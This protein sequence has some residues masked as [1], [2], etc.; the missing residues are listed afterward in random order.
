MDRIRQSAG[1]RASRSARLTTLKMFGPADQ[2]VPIIS[3]RVI[4]G[5]LFRFLD[6]RDR[7][8]FKMAL[9][10]V[11][12]LVCTRI[13]S[14]SSSRGRGLKLRYRP[15]SQMRARLGVLL[16]YPGSTSRQNNVLIGFQQ[17]LGSN[18]RHPVKQPHPFTHATRQRNAH[19]DSIVLPRLHLRR[20]SCCRIDFLQR[21][22]VFRYGIACPSRELSIPIASVPAH[23]ASSSVPA[24]DNKN[25][26][27]RWYARLASRAVTERGL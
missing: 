3:F 7:G 5:L 14:G 23:V 9:F 21:G 11:G 18:I 6:S 1:K 16:S 4:S 24:T 15:E 12:T 13:G 22:D 10:L 26:S 19:N 20:P 27:A 25:L 17:K 8:R 2:P